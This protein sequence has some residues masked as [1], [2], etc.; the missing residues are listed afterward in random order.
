MLKPVR[1]KNRISF[2]PA[3]LLALG[4]GWLLYQFVKAE[5]VS[6]DAFPPPRPTILARADWGARALKGFA[7]G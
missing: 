3:L 5:T 1:T 4:F 7:H 6:L 2:W